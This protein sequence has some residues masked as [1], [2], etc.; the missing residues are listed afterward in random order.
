MVDYEYYVNC[1]LGTLIPQKEFSALAGRAQA[2]LNRLCRV[3]QVEAD[4]ESKAMAL[5]AMAEELYRGAS[6]E[7]L[8]GASIGSVSVQYR[9]SDRET[10]HRRLYRAASVYL[11]IY[12]GKGCYGVSAV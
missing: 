3:Y 4:K 1:Y 2:Y 9:L 7:G 5:C 11:D 6:R 8:S 10:E 12:R